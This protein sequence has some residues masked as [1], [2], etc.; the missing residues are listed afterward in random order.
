MLCAGAFNSPKLLLLS[1]IGDP[2]ALRAVGVEPRHDLPGVGKN[3]QDHLELY[4]QVQS[5]QPITLYSSLNLIAKAQIGLRWL[6]RKDG[7]G[8]TNHFEACA[9]I[10]SKAG[11]AYPD[12]QYHFL[13]V[14]IRYDGTAPAEGHGF[15]AHVGPMRSASR[16]QVWLQ[17]SEPEAPPRIL[18]NYLSAE[19]DM[20]DFRRCIRLTREIF[21][22]DAFSPYC[23]RELQPGD[24]AQDDAALD[25]YVREHVESAYHPCGTCKMG[26]ADDPQAVVDPE[27]RVIGLEGLRVADSAIIP[28]ITN[29]NLNGPS[30]MI[31]E[32][33]ADIVLG[34]P[35]LAPSNATPWLHPEWRTRQR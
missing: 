30:I 2:N 7:L 22:Q 5:L 15:Q 27:C 10:R 35:T 34:R 25:A 8:A 6:L 4:I 19:E 33:A 11:V 23:G 29:G 24:A 13:P 18:F 17:S 12:I 28:R 14:A 20:E 31:G 9:F 26:S 16:G 1:G 3:L 21:A 32:K